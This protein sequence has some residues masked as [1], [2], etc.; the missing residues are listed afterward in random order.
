MF[1]KKYNRGKIMNQ[2][3]FEQIRRE[4]GEIKSIIGRLREN[5]SIAFG[6]EKEELLSELIN[7]LL[8][9]MKGEEVA[10]YPY[11]RINDRLSEMSFRASEEHHIA[12]VVLAELQ[13]TPMNDVRWLAK[14][15]VLQNLIEQH[16]EMEETLVFQAMQENLNDEQIKRISEQYTETKERYLVVRF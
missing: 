2:E 14:L 1:I 8:P 9:H 10:M 12:R 3:F 13:E 5:R 16:I 7:I 11:L 6:R 15:I 4:H